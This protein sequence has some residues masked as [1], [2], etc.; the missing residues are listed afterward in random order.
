MH[1][2]R[3]INRLSRSLQ[4]IVLVSLSSLLVLGCGID[5]YVYL[6]PPRNVIQ[7]GTTLHFENDVGNDVSVF[8]GYLL[9]YRFFKTSEEAA[10]S[11]TQIASAFSSSPT[12]IYLRMQNL[13]YNELLVNGS[14]YL[15][16][17]NMAERGDLFSIEVSFGTR[18]I[19]GVTIDFAPSSAIVSVNPG[20]PALV[21]RKPKNSS[22]EYF[23]F[24]D[25][26]F[27]ENDS[28]LKSGQYDP[29]TGST[30]LQCYVLSY[31]F[32]SNGVE[33][34]YSEPVWFNG[35]LLIFSML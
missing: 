14:P 1:H 5:S 15:N 8:R 19:T 9:L 34:I 10:S 17:T 7:N 32:S 21:T 25:S 18:N 23:G 29:S 31:G 3:T 12:T 16:V 13:G 33:S 22:S 11:R 35:S 26:D 27:V 24:K 20:F 28:D 30:Y 2:A 4:T 6:A